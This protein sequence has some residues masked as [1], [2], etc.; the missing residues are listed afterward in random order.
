MIWAI[1]AITILVL[2]W[3]IYVNYWLPRIAANFDTKCRLLT[4]EDFMKTN[5][6][7]PEESKNHYMRRLHWVVLQRHGLPPLSIVKIW[8]RSNKPYILAPCDQIERYL[9]E[10]KNTPLPD[11]KLDPQTS[12]GQGWA[13]FKLMVN[14]R[15]TRVD[16]LGDFWLGGKD[17]PA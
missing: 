7:L 3:L 8:L 14:E 10:N 2:L 13:I 12:N 17:P 6:Q 15:I 16:E 11:G 4:V 9:T 1:I 5:P